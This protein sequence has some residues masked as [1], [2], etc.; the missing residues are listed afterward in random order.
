MLFGPSL[1]SSAR[2]AWI[3]RR[4]DRRLSALRAE[5]E[6]LTRERERL[7][8]DPAYVEGL[9]RTTFKWAKPGEYVIPLD[10]E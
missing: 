6:R 1:V 2:L 3:E 8:A 10:T 7:H 5:E 4:L 9:I